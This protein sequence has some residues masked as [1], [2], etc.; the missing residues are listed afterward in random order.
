MTDEQAFESIRNELARA[1][2]KFPIW[3]SDG[4]HAAA[5]VAEESGELVRACLQATY[6]GGSASA[7]GD[8]A[9]HVGAMAVRFLVGK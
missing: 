8:E 7:C 9:V 5:V 6:E 2:A 3:P 4:I 1:R